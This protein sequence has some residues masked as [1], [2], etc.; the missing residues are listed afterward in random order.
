MD[1]TQK[2]MELLIAS[3][4]MADQIL[5]NRQECVSLDKRRQ[6]TRV[7]IRDLSK[8]DD[9]KTWITVGSLLVKMTKERALDL[10]TKGNENMI[11]CEIYC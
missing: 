9:R 11:Q 7:A 4:R 2:T 1:G 10:L 8:C 5:Q 6:E 3:E